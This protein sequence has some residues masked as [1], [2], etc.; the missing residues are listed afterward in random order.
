MKKGVKNEGKSERIRRKNK[1]KTEIEA[2]ATAWR[3]NFGVS[4][5]EDK[6]HRQRRGG[7]KD[8]LWEYMYKPLVRTYL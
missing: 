5:E 3:I 8:G 1:G 7:E 2:K 6:Y 4:L